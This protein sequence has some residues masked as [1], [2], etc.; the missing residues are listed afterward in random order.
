MDKLAVV[1]LSNGANEARCG[2]WPRHEA[3][4]ALPG[5]WAAQ[6]GSSLG[7]APPDLFDRRLGGQPFRLGF[8]KQARQFG[9]AL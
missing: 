5:L 9:A 2:H 7:F 6:S 1:P 8:G 3:V 4:R